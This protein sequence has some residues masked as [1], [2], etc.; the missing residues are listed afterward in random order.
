MRDIILSFTIII[1]FLAVNVSA[2]YYKLDINQQGNKASLNESFSLDNSFKSII[3]NQ[4]NIDSSGNNYYFT[5]KAIP[6]V[7]N[8]I[9]IK[10]IL[11]EGF[12]VNENDIYPKNFNLETDG[13]RIIIIWNFNELKDSKDIPLFLKFSAARFF[14]FS[15]FSARSI[16]CTLRRILT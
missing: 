5:Y 11:S 4:E 13:H 1:L 8:N 10:F 2:D 14:R 6:R 9:T 3:L 7:D 16:S 15:R 12:T